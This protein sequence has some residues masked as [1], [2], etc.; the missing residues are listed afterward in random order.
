MLLGIVVRVVRML[1]WI[2]SDEP[3][4]RKVVLC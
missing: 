2:I 3:S 4:E 1:N